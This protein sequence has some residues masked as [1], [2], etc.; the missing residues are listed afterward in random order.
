MLPRRK[1]R[2]GMRIEERI[3][4]RVR[5]ERR[6]RR[7]SQEAL[8]A[9]ISRYLPRPWSAQTVSAAENGGRDFAAQDILALAL[10]LGVPVQAFYREAVETLGQEIQMPSGVTVKEP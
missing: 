9:E 6:A 5:E 7:W 2:P 10:V 8:G 4:A 1:R 3:G